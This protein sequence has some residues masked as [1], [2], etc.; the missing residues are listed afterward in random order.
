MQMLK[1]MNV[2]FLTGSVPTHRSSISHPP[3]S[4]PSY[5]TAL[6]YHTMYW[7][8]STPQA[9]GSCL[10]F[11]AVLLYTH[12][13]PIHPFPGSSAS[14]SLWSPPLHFNNPFQIFN[15]TFPSGSKLLWSGTSPTSPLESSTSKIMWEI[16]ANIDWNFRCW[17]LYRHSSL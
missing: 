10:S 17:I 15:L 3:S 11:S 9:P 1:L 6:L 7:D 13:K 2:T 12:W 8:N 16:M 14:P 5:R 4:R